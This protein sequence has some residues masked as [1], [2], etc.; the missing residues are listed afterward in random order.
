MLVKSLLS[1][2][3]FK[4]KVKQASKIPLAKHLLIPFQGHFQSNLILKTFTQAHIHKLGKYNNF[5]DDKPAGA[6]ILATQVVG[7]ALKLYKTGVPVQV[8]KDK[9]FLT[10]NF[11]DKTIH[12][13]VTG[14]NGIARMVNVQLNHTSH[15]LKMIKDFDNAHWNQILQ[16]AHEFI[17]V[18]DESK[19]MREVEMVD[20]DNDDNDIV[21]KS[22]VDNSDLDKE[23]INNAK[24]EG[25]WEV[26]AKGE[27]ED[28]NNSASF[29][30][31][32]FNIVIH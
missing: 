8:G 20:N 19:G 18:D 29:A 12:K 15:Y 31:L 14:A 2:V 11:G 28:D 5:D 6:L 30:S 3:E 25:D 9:H 22:D 26:I 7:H 21:F 1:K 27:G 23:L 4:M 16:S 10:D 32:S 17:V 24:D 13:Q